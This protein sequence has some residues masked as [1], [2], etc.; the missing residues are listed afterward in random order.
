MKKENEI[1]GIKNTIFLLKKTHLDKKIYVKLI[2]IYIVSAISA[3]FNAIFNAKIIE[4]IT[5]TNFNNF[6]VIVL[7][8]GLAEAIKMIF[9]NFQTIFNVKLQNMMV[10][11]INNCNYKRVLSLEVSNFNNNSSEEFQN[12]IYSAN[13]ISTVI[14]N[15]LANLYDT[16]YYLSY[17]FVI[18][19]YCPLLSLIYIIYSILSVTY[20][21]LLTPYI[22]NL[23]NKNW[24]NNGI[25]MNSLSRE[26]IVGIKDIKSL[27]MIDQIILD[28]DKKQTKY[29]NE[30]TRINTFSAKTNFIMS[31]F[32]LI[33]DVSVPLLGYY[34]YTKNMLTIPKFILFMTYK[35]NITYL[36]NNVSNFIVN[37]SDVEANAIRGS[38]LYDDKIFASE[39]FGNINKNNLIGNIKINNLDFSYENDR[40]LFK[41]LNLT[42]ESNQI[43]AIVGRS[44]EGKTT[45]L[46]LINKFYNV[47]NDK[48]FIDDI[49]INEYDESTIR[50][51]IAYIQQS[52]YIFNMT[53]REN[54][55]LIKPNATEEELIEVCKK[56]EIYDFICSTKNGL[57]TMIGENGITISGG[58]KQRLAIA[59]ALL[60]NANIIMFDESTSSLDNESQ[61]KIQ[62][63]IE[64]LSVDHT[65]IIVA[66]RLSTIKNANKII[67]IKNH[68][69]KAVG[70]HSE[71]MLS[72]EDYK[73]LY[74]IESIN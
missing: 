50:N 41:N 35:S 72:C 11:E 19:F 32:A 51:N 53:F 21:K 67:F 10:K 63:V 5:A 70:N 23:Y 71:L 1:K 18:L 61:N 14:T 65:I 36:F 15:S 22:N 42:I 13:Q 2:L 40:Q 58:Q 38:Q 49:D 60:N 28:Y 30:Q 26:A 47:D 64:K 54:L 20:R 46:S 52:P 17:T 74:K 37:V 12:R 27:N 55:L 3:I 43:N 59:R 29:Y 16:I 73:N 56:S 34:L 7:C 6:I 39:Q 62:K 69:V 57:D 31:F 45:I 48:I 68:T 8:L 66:H 24:K 25:S 44:G 4:H 33:R 9:Q